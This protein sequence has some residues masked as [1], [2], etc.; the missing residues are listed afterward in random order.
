MT[1]FDAGCLTVVMLGGV[2]AFATGLSIAL[3]GKAPQR[4]QHASVEDPTGVAWILVL[5]IAFLEEFPK[6]SL[7]M[8]RLFLGGLLA[9]AVAGIASLVA[10]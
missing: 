10:A 7:F 2:F 4:L 5:P 1:P 6:A 8:R 9:A 3:Q